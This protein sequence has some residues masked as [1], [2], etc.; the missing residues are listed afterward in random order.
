MTLGLAALGTISALSGQKDQ[1]DA[2]GRAREAQ[3]AQARELVKQMNY[4]DV[5]LNQ[6]D[7]DNYDQAVKQLEENSINAIRNRGMIQ[8]ALSETGLEGRSVDALVR[9]VEGSDARRADSI[10]ANYTTQRRGIQY[11]SEMSHS[12][13]QGAITGMPSIAGPSAVSSALSVINGGMAGAA[14]GASL[15]AS[16]TKS[17]TAAAAGTVGS[18]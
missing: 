5:A 17:T 13:T 2:V 4:K 6:Q 16:I 7:R 18:K 8:A 12:Q 1:A 11:E 3:A 14:A 9:E 15:K 10:R